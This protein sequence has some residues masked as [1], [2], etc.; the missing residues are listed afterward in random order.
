MADS[1]EGVGMSLA[2]PPGAQS[3]NRSQEG[4][5]MDPS[6]SGEGGAANTPPFPRQPEDRRHTADIPLDPGPPGSSDRSAD[7]PEAFVPFGEPSPRDAP[8]DDPE[9]ARSWSAG[10]STR[11]PEDLA[12]GPAGRRF[13]DRAGDALRHG[14]E[15]SL[16]T[17][18]ARFADR[19]DDTAARIERLADD[20]LQG[21][22]TRRR[23]GEVAHSSAGW[24]EDAADYLRS[25]DLDRLRQDVERQVREKPLQSLLLAV[26]AG[27]VL[28]K[29][30][31]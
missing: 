5:S 9:A 29:I 28:G 15:R 7:D 2:A 10:G 4:A 31:R 18:F 27:W 14:A 17:G 26:T 21:S 11:E 8:G 25:S 24:L 16:K 12:A 30:M 1:G 19:L 20:Q 22:G 3:R 13:R 6:R 23:A